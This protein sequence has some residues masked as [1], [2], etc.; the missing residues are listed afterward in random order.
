MPI[1]TIR[2]PRN[3]SGADPT[4][5]VTRAEA[6]RRLDVNASG[7]LRKMMRC[8]L[9]PESPTDADVGRWEGRPF[10]GLASG[11]LTVLRTDSKEPS[12]PVYPKDPR[13]W[14]GYDVTMTDVE[15]EDASL[16]WWRCKPA[17]VLYNELFAVTI[18]EFPVALYL[19]HEHVDQRRFGD[20][21]FD[22]HRF[23]GALLARLDDNLELDVRSSP[24][25][26]ESDVRTIMS[27]R[28]RTTSGGPIGY[29][30]VD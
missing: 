22:R 5:L 2:P 13:R 4:R 17:R 14:L 27:S 29:L 25:L 6:A 9:L 12:P 19:L 20:E 10:L 23:A 28:I 15:L 8:G 16:R 1:P 3:S 24:A 11:E 18:A 30:E 26:P 21:E 7:G